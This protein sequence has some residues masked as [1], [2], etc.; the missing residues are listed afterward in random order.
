MLI[1]KD[2]KGKEYTLEFN[3]KTI[4]AMENNGFVLNLDAPMTCV[5]SLFY[6]AFQ[7]HH[8][9]IDHEFVRKVWNAQRGKEALITA[10]VSEYKKPL[11]ELMDEPVDEET[12]NTEEDLALPIYEEVEW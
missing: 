12:D 3:R 7:M 6:G 4:M 8:K 1:V 9:K 5:D 2:S 11:D 10:L